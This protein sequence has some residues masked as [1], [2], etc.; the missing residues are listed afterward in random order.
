MN[1]KIEMSTSQPTDHGNKNRQQQRTMLVGAIFLAV[2]LLV[3]AVMLFSDD[4]S[5]NATEITYD[6]P[7]I[8]DER[9]SDKKFIQNNKSIEL[10]QSF[11]RIYRKHY[12]QSLLVNQDQ[13]FDIHK[14]NNSHTIDKIDNY[15]MGT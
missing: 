9:S 7:L 4:F 3:T 13:K 10:Q 1:Q 8:Q 5:T 2:G 11:K 12:L 15:N 6:K 14:I